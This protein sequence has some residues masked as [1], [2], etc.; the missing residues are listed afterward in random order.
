[1]DTSAPCLSLGIVLCCLGILLVRR[2]HTGPRTSR[3]VSRNDLASFLK[4]PASLWLLFLGV[5]VTTS[6]INITQ[7]DGHTWED[8]FLIKS[9]KVEIHNFFFF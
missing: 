7:V 8:F 2:H 3:T 4:Q 9:L 6:G 5:D 1:M